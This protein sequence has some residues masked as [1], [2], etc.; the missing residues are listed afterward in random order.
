VGEGF[1]AGVGAEVGEGATAS[2]EAGVAGDCVGCTDGVGVGAGPDDVAPDDVA[3][4]PSGLSSAG[5]C[6]TT[7][8]GSIAACVV[9]GTGTAVAV[10]SGSGSCP[11]PA[12]T[13]TL[14]DSTNTSL[15]YAPSLLAKMIFIQTDSFVRK[16]FPIR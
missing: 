3:E 7:G 10:R 4:D 5:T 15:Q 2:I 9:A 6:V 8:V 12:N 11:H 14:N 13:N 16:L 1:G